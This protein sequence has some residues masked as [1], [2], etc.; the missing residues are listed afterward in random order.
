MRIKLGFKKIYALSLL[1]CVA[2]STPYE[3]STS[4][5]KYPVKLDEPK[6]TFATPS[7]KDIEKIIDARS[8]EMKKCYEE[9]VALDPNL[10][11]KV[12]VRF[13]LQH[14]GKIRD[15]GIH[16]TTLK[17]PMV[18][19]CLQYQITKIK[20]PAFSKGSLDILHPFIFRLKI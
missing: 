18:E 15:I 6:T 13:N 1:V 19:S 14:T 20:F 17:N 3:V 8:D 2:C 9:G 12:I 11:G 4:G 10:A 16:E 5:G 7:Q